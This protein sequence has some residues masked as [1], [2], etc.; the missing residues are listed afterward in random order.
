MQSLLNYTTEK[1]SEN[2][3]KKEV[4]R[5]LMKDAIARSLADTFKF[6]KLP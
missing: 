5:K 3:K 4:I 6:I 2:I 1:L